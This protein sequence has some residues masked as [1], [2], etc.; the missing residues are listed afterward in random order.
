MICIVSQ[1]KK[2]PSLDNYS[3]IPMQ[4]MSRVCSVKQHLFKCHPCILCLT[5]HW[6]YGDNLPCY[7]TNFL[8]VMENTLGVYKNKVVFNTFCFLFRYSGTNTGN[9]HIIADLYAEVT[10]VLAQSK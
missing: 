3:K 6:F 4:S 5:F 7:G 1:S 9:V 8:F 2:S 10:G